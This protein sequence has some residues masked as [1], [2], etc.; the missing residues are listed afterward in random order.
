MEH[1]WAF[2]HYTPRMDRQMILD[3]LEQARRH[4]AEG[5]EH[6][7]RQRKIIA[8]LERDGHDTKM[9]RELLTQFEETFAIH[10]EDQER[11]ERELSTAG[12]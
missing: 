4:V 3:H 7:A 8:E 10:V 2:L 9:A 11:I 12:D 6:L 1:T 5:K